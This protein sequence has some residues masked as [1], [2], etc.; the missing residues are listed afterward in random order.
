LN[1]GEFP[2]ARGAREY[3]H[4]T[5]VEALKEA[6]KEL[7][8]R[9]NRRPYRR[10]RHA[11]RE[12]LRTILRHEGQEYPPLNRVLPQNVLGKEFHCQQ[13]VAIRRNEVVRAMATG[14][15]GKVAR[16]YLNQRGWLLRARVEASV[17]PLFGGTAVGMGIWKATVLAGSA[18]VAAET[19][20]TAAVSGGVNLAVAGGIG[21]TLFRNERR[22]AK[23]LRYAAQWLEARLGPLGFAEIAK[24]PGSATDEEIQ[25]IVTRY[26]AR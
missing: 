17:A 15:V 24:L 21:Y 7:E 14:D 2:G 3:A 6:F 18:A 9:C 26:S 19:V 11:V 4:S 25:A 12:H 13:V 1:Q 23:T 22:S 5:V 20:A 10:A 8:P 16:Q